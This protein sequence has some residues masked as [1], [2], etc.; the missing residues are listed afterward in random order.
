MWISQKNEMNSALYADDK[1]VEK[2]MLL[3]RSKVNN[4]CETDFSVEKIGFS[5]ILCTGHSCTKNTD[6]SIV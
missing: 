1:P 5:S 4:F 6:F 2:F 3:R